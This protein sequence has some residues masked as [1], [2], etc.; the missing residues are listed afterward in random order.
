MARTIDV[1]I[2]THQGW[3]LT[4]QCLEHLRKQTVSHTVIVSDSASTDGTSENIRAH[5]PHVKLLTDAED[6]GYAAATNHGV[7]AGSGDVIVLLNNDAFCR[8]DFLE[9]VVAAFEDDRVGAVAP[10]TVRSDEATIDSV[11]LTVDVTLAPFIRLTGRPIEDAASERPLLAS[12]GGGADAYRRSAW[13]EAGGLDERL[14]FYGCRSRSRAG[15]PLARVDD[16]C[17]TRCGCGPHSLGDERAP[18]EARSPVGRLGSR[19]P[20]PALGG[21]EEPLGDTDHRDG[22][23]RGRRGHGTLAGRDRGSI[24]HQRL[25]GCPSSTSP[26]G[27]SRRFGSGD[28]LPR[29]PSVPLVCQVSRASAATVAVASATRPTAWLVR[30][31]SRAHSRLTTGTPSARSCPFDGCGAQTQPRRSGDEDA[32][33]S[34][35]SSAW[36]CRMSTC[37]LGTGRSST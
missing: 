33:T 29:E 19:L 37:S 24:A 15:A 16:G 5:F 35:V 31:P 30:E 2:T 9:H 12:P 10:L 11:G 20:H 7:A 26:T 23:G 3:E 32:G 18:F 28:R 34:S 1:V 25:E 6:P 22:G 4:E 17:R 27:A 14:S 13:M 36:S 21:P 8:P